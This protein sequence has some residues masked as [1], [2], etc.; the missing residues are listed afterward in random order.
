MRFDAGAAERACGATRR[1][2]YPQGAPAHSTWKNS[3]IGGERG[4]SGGGGGEVGGAIQVD[5]YKSCIHEQYI[6]YN[7]DETSILGMLEYAC[8]RSKISSKSKIM[9]TVSQRI[10][11]CRQST[12][13]IAGHGKD[14]NTTD[15]KR[16]KRSEDD[17]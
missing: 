12:N 10:S 7:H 5:R 13:G 3:K 1:R 17:V 9:W 15:G 14:D 2:V 16:R 11:I 6:T 8:A 4:R